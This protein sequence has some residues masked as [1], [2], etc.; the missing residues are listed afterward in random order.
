MFEKVKQKAILENV[1]IIKSE[2]EQFIISEL[3]NTKP[4]N[5]VEI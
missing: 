5:V 4:Q 2:A 1:P 3:N